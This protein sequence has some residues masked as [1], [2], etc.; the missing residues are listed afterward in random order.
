MPPLSFDEFRSFCPVASSL[1]I[2]GDRW[3]LVLIRDFYLGATRYTDFLTSPEGIPSNLLAERLKTL[4]TRGI[5]FKTPY[6]TRPTRYDYRL[7]E[8]GLALYPVMKA[9]T[10]WG[11]DWLPDR[12]AVPPE[13]V[14]WV[15]RVRAER[16]T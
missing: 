7:T 13:D 8:M 5:V 10:R 4:E 1:D 2:I 14:E 12:K 16:A 9:L 3:T 15:R 11:L 6:Q